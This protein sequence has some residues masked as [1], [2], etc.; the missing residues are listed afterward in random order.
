MNLFK[1]IKEI[2]FFKSTAEKTL[3]IRLKEKRKQEK[4]WGGIVKQLKKDHKRDELEMQ[5]D[6]IYERKDIIEEKNGRIKDSDK[7]WEMFKHKV[8][9]LDFLTEELDC[10]VETNALIEARK[11]QQMG[12]MRGKIQI[13]RNWITAN[14]EKIIRLSRS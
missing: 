9:E 12:K 13:L 10:M 3:K 2:R 5:Q 8:A 7:A 11:V 6:H 1:L 14:D 4:K